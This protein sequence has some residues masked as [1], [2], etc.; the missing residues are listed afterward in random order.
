MTH[1][2]DDAPFNR[3]DGTLFHAGPV[4][5]PTVPEHDA[6]GDLHYDVDQILNAAQKSL[7]ASSGLLA[8]HTFGDSGTDHVAKH[9]GNPNTRQSVADA[10]TAECA[11]LAGTPE[12][13]A[14][15]YHL[16]DLIYPD[17]NRHKYEDEFYKPFEHYPNAIVAVPGNHDYYGDHLES[18][19]LNF[20]QPVLEHKPHVRPRMNLPYYHWTL[21]TP[22]AT[23][24]GLATT[25]D[26]VSQSQQD[27]FD[28]EMKAAS[29]DKALIVA[30]HYPP[31]CA[32]G[33]NNRGVR[34]SIARAIS[35]ATRTPDLVISGHSHNYQRIEG[36]YPVLVVGTGGVSADPVSRSVANDGAR[37]MA[38][39]GDSFGA[40]TLTVNKNT[41]TIEGRFATAS[42]HA[43]DLLAPGQSPSAPVLP[44]G[45]APNA[46]GTPVL[47]QFSYPWNV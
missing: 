4:P 39:S 33:S 44:H 21:D 8:F 17:G 6:G 34:H 30:T 5:G 20:M 10:I 11:A 29:R 36:P 46:A 19:R 43:T 16:G 32:D 9:N 28:S 22:V 42:W 2:P 41:R 38:S 31:Y 47:D 12:R 25:S 14:F 40:V 26:Y 3:Y 18:Y 45:Q 7:I 23:I 1:S 13:P 35:A 24:I 15:C 27:W 37:L